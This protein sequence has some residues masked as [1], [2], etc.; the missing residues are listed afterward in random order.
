MSDMTVYLLPSPP[1]L[2]GDGMTCRWRPYRQRPARDIEGL[3]ALDRGFQPD[4]CVWGEVVPEVLVP[5]HEDRDS[6]ALFNFRK[7]AAIV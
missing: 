1:R 4:A 2:I 5:C 6:A 7:D 3:P